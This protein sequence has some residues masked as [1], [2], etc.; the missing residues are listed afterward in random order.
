M[1]PRP[2]H[3]S[4]ALA[5][6]SKVIITL[7]ADL[8]DPATIRKIEGALSRASVQLAQAIAKRA[9]SKAP[10]DTGAL[11]RSF[12]ARR[13][14][15]K[16]LMASVAT[17]ADYFPMIEGGRDGTQPS[18][19]DIKAWIIRH[20]LR[21]RAR[22]GRAPLTGQAAITAV[23]YAVARSEKQVKANPFYQQA[24]REVF[25]QKAR[26]IFEREL[27]RVLR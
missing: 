6:M 26:G 25:R 20:R 4:E 13:G 8:S 10:R 24:Q 16:R 21:P 23:A 14:D 17:S 3:A 1:G 15:G 5:L 7:Q 27:R 22:G 2:D 12:K 19:S 18:I 11:A 9:A